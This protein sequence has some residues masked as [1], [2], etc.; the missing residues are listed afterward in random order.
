MSKVSLRHLPIRHY[1]FNS[2]VVCVYVYIP[3]SFKVKGRGP[4]DEDKAKNL[5]IE[6]DSFGDRFADKRDMVES[7]QWQSLV[8]TFF[9]TRTITP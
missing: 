6:L 1:M 2:F 5:L 7:Q 8:I 9:Q 3:S 4:L